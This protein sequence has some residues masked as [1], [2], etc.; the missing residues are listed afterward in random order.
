MRIFSVLGISETLRSKLPACTQ[1]VRFD[2]L[3]ETQTLGHINTPAKA[4]NGYLSHELIRVNFSAYMTPTDHRDSDSRDSA[5]A[6]LK[7]EAKHLLMDQHKETYATLII[8]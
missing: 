8:I 2:H 7:H 1:L 3:S 6:I 5:G 4:P